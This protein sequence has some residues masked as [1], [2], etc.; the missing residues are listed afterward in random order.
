MKA[1]DVLKAASA[2]EDLQ[3]LDQLLCRIGRSGLMSVR[4]EFVS[5]DPVVLHGKNSQFLRDA[6]STGL[7]AERCRLRDL[8]RDL[9]VEVVREVA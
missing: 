8:L 9:D 6:L 4:V 1:N 7:L 3:T 2:I 5:D